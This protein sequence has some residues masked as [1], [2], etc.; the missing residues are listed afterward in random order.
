MATKKSAVTVLTPKEHAAIRRKVQRG[1]QDFEEGKY[2][3][4][5]AKGLRALPAILVAESMKRLSRRKTA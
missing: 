4:F 5:D 3:V 1:I 2:E